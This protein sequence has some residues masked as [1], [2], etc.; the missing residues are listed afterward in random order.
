MDT[1]PYSGICGGALDITWI[2]IA[3]LCNS[4]RK[5]TSIVVDPL[6]RTMIG[7]GCKQKASV[8]VNCIWNETFLQGEAKSCMIET[9]RS[10]V[11]SQVFIPS[12]VSK[13][14]DLACFKLSLTAI[15]V[16]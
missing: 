8:L 14:M 1:L 16:F 7:Y 15:E 2:S 10:D 4:S 6:N 12:K 3:G 11:R 5:D 13:A 9:V